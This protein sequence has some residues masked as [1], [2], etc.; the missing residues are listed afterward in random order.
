LDEANQEIRPST[1]YEG[2][3][4]ILTIHDQRNNAEVE[5]DEMALLVPWS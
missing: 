1:S 3:V 5:S 2:G 4:L